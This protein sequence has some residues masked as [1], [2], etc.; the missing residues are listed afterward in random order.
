VI[1]QIRQKQLRRQSKNRGDKQQLGDV[2][3]RVLTKL[4]EAN[5]GQR[6]K[7]EPLV[8]LSHS[9][10]GQIVYDLVTYFMPEIPAYKNLRIDFWCASASQVGLFEELKLFRASND[11]YGKQHNNQVP[12]PDRRYLGGWWNVWDHNDFISYSAKNIIADVDDQDYNSGMSVI[13]AHRGYVER[14][15]F[16]RAFAEKLRLAK[17]QSSGS[18]SYYDSRIATCFTPKQTTRL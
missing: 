1:Y 4:K 7:D 6:D 12:L 9:M 11:Q 3:S 18:S 13:Q 2:S 5:Q 8:V 16:F 10:G 15:S 14:P 17:N